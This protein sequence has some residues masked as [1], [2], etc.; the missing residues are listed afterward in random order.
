[1]LFKTKN[2]LISGF[3]ALA[4]SSCI[5]INKSL[6]RP[7]YHVQFKKEDF[8]YSNQVSGEATETKIFFIDWERLLLKKS[9]DFGA[10]SN[11]SDPISNV[12]STIP[13]IGGNTGIGAAKYAVHNIIKD[14]P[15]YDAVL[16]PQYDIESKNFLIVTYTKVKVSARLGKL[17][18]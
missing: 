16:F 17:K 8:E 15:G 9:G 13:I 1:M 18:K 4:L 12:I 3:A 7:N 6:D 2:L 5:G 11:A 14:N 10:L